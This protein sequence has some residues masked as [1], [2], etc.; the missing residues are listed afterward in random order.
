MLNG[1]FDKIYG[2]WED[3]PIGMALLLTITV[4]IG[5]IGLA[6]GIMCLKAWLIMMLW[7]WVAVQVFNFPVISFWLAFGIGWLISV[8]FKNVI[9]I[10]H[11]N[12]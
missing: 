12:N 9:Q 2:F 5:G 3:Y 8:L 4:V 10:N 7:N 11:N 1:V 6:F